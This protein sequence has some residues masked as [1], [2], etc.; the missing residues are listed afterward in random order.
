MLIADLVE[1]WQPIEHAFEE[2]TTDGKVRLA[3]RASPALGSL[4]RRAQTVRE[5]LERKMEKLLE[6]AGIAEHLQ[7]GAPEV[8]TLA[9]ARA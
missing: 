4:R 8:Q 5:E 2:G 3:D 1:V 7:V 9:R 6:H